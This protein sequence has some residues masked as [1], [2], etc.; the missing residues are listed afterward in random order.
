MTAVRGIRGAT[1]VETDTR[2]EILDATEELLIELRD[3]NRIDPDDVASA[4]F[5]TT[6]DL[7]AAFPAEAARVRLGWEHA[8]LMGA[9]EITAPGADERCIR[10]L[11]HVNTDKRQD[12][13]KFVY[14]RGTGNLRFRGTDQEND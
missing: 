9:M 5:T 1:K 10:V 8:A 14:L 6:P 13:M 12:E 3:Q 11:I 4:L 7:T 2:D